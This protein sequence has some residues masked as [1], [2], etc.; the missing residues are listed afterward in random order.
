MYTAALKSQDL[1]TG[2][3]PQLASLNYRDSGVAKLAGFLQ[4]THV[5][6]S[7]AQTKHGYNCLLVAQDKLELTPII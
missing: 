7:P 2:S 1:E 4:R 5:T 3:R 6:T